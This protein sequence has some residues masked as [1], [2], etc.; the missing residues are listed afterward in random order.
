MRSG[1]PICALR[2]SVRRTSGSGC[3]G[4][5]TATV[6]DAVAGARSANAKRGP[7][8]GLQTAAQMAG[9]PTPDTNQRGGSQDPE[10]RK[11]G[12]H[13]VTLQDAVRMAGWPAP[14]K[15]N[16][17]GS[18][19]GKDA[20]ATGRR[21]NGTK[22]TVSLNH[23][24]TL[25]GWPTATTRDHKDGSA[26]SCQNVPVNALLGRAVHLEGWASPQCHDS[27][28]PK[29]PEQVAT[30]PAKGHGVSNLNEQSGLTQDSLPAGT[31]RAG[32]YRL[33]PLFSL[34]LMGFPPRG[35]ASCAERAMPSCRRSRRSSL[36]PLE[37]V[38]K[39]TQRTGGTKDEG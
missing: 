1:P 31:G 28:M 37:G 14:T 15:G 29:T 11:A 36:P 38:E 26:E 17:D 23:L 3:I 19:M 22:A 6:S 27:S 30:M 39:G 33:N 16:A 8:P 18:Q 13:S 20:S 34:W 32:G 9:W 21:P 35:W 4:W 24:A 10:K 25:A 12:G 7:A 2:A 5:P